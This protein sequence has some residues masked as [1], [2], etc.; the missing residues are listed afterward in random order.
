VLKPSQTSG[1]HPT[2][3]PR[4]API[5]TSTA[6]PVVPSSFTNLKCSNCKDSG[7]YSRD[8]PNAPAEQKALEDTAYYNEN[9]EPPEHASDEDRQDPEE[10]FDAA[11]DSSE[12]DPG[13]DSENFSL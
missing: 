5:V 1:Q 11:W 3:T 6:K 9:E 4:P 10:F 12:S 13:Q 2:S 7:H 8:C